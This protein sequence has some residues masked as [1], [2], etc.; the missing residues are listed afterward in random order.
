M[1]PRL[2]NVTVKPG[3]KRPGIAVEN[4][5]VV[6]RVAE[7]AI[8]G[9]ANAGCVRALAQRLGVAPSSITLT[10]GAA[11]RRKTFA[12]ATIEIDEALRRLHESDA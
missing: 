8:E 1:K 12:L 6:V 9:A 5:T 4:G 7:R 10:G 3:S 2:L 11:A